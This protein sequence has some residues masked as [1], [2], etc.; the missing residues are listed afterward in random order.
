[1]TQM[2]TLWKYQE[3]EAKLDKLRKEMDDT[4][5]MKEYKKLRSFLRSQEAKMASYKA[6]VEAKTAEIEEA[7]KKLEALLN[8]YDLEQGDLEIM[9][10]DEECTAEE[11][12][13]SRRSIEALAEKV[14]ALKKSLSDS[15]AWI[16]ETSEEMKKTMA[17]GRKANKEYET[18][19]AVCE[20]ERNERKPVIDSAAKEVERIGLQISPDL[21][22]RYKVV[23]KK[24]ALPMA[25][26]RDDRCGGC[27]MSL[28]KTVL[29]QVALGTEIVECE[30]CGR[31]LC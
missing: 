14:N 8:D 17:R 13:E 25:R 30:N 3:A 1:M 27:G 26:L 4:P 21:L 31:I 20:T 24:H 23:K 15:L 28:P 19:K 22:K 16:N 12:T 29:R 10:N 2:E 7:S 9:I 18:A 5:A 6:G 11:L